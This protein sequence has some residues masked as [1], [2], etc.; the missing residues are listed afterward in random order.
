MAGTTT[1]SLGTP[2]LQQKA[3]R[4]LIT[5]K[6]TFRLSK[7]VSSSMGCAWD[8]HWGF[9]IDGDHAKKKTMESWSTLS[10]KGPKGIN[11]PSSWLHTGPPKIQTLSLR[12][13]T[14]NHLTLLYILHCSVLSQEAIQHLGREQQVGSV[15]QEPARLGSCSTPNLLPESVLG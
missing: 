1:P 6:T 4:F 10:V 11:E 12:T 15:G 8:Q 7:S 2:C 5:G 9:C 13:E 3:N 14:A